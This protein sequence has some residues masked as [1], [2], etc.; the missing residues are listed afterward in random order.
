MNKPHKHVELIK[1]WAD[2]AQI[3]FKARSDVDWED[4]K[5]NEALG[6][7]DN[8]EYR[9]KPEREYPVT[10]ITLL[11]L[12]EIYSCGYSTNGTK[13]A[14]D[15]ALLNVAKEVIKQ[16]IIDTEGK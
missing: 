11:K 4:A 10:S 9:I 12:L 1:A 6:W 15:N 14:H 13:S 2:G 3:Q 8:L 7:I 16:H 5:P